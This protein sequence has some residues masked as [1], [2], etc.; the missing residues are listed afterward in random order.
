MY[1]SPAAESYNFAITVFSWVLPSSADQSV[2]QLVL[3]FYLLTCSRSIPH[4]STNQ[5]W[6]AQTRS[7]VL[8][9]GGDKIHS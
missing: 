6:R 7:Q 2:I 4:L 1:D 8:R 9:F 3:C 5:T